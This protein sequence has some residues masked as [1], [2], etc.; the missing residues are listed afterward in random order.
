MSL[1]GSIKS[2]SLS[3]SSGSSSNHLPFYQEHFDIMTDVALNG[4]PASNLT[5]SGTVKRADGSR[6][7][8]K[9]NV[10]GRSFSEDDDSVFLSKDKVNPVGSCLNNRF[11]RSLDSTFRRSL[12]SISEHKKTKPFSPTRTLSTS[13]GSSL[14]LFSSE[15]DCAVRSLTNNKNDEDETVQSPASSY[16]SWIESVNNIENTT[17]E[18]QPNDKNDV[19]GK[20]GEWN[21]FWLN[22]NTAR[23]RYMSSTYLTDDRMA[24]DVSEAISSNS[25]QKGLGEKPPGECIFLTVDEIHEALKY[26]KKLTEILQ[27]ALIRSNHDCEN[28]N[29]ETSFYSESFS[30][31]NSSPK[32]DN[33]SIF[34][35]EDLK[36]VARERSASYI[37]TTQE[38]MK[39]KELVKPSNQ[40]SSTSCINAILNTGVAD[41]LKRVI[42]KRRDIMTPDD[43]SSVT[44]SFS[45]WGGK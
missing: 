41:I 11:R 8:I 18:V 31:R 44:R 43:M 20:V 40:S 10:V 16:L 29:P 9:K 2:N 14:D 12:E 4:S 5:R 7:F 27:T 21:N 13:R 23:N 22:Y 26:S 17:T 30:R 19:E 3:E 39:Q 34:T 42:S 28:S 32:E 33:G 36:R 6:F 45:E 38:H 37:I 35:K 24:D 25:T 1:D 15:Q